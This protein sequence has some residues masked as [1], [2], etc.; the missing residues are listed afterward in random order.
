[1]LKMPPYQFPLYVS[2]L[3]ERSP[4]PE[5]NASHR[6]QPID[7]DLLGPLEPSPSSSQPM[8]REIRCPKSPNALPF[9]SIVAV[10]AGE[11]VSPTV[12]IHVRHRSD[13]NSILFFRLLH[14]STWPPILPLVVDPISSGPNCRARR[15]PGTQIC[16]VVPRLDDL[17]IGGMPLRK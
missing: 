6:R 15:Y 4:P 16:S 3:W 5:Q 14:A 10:G 13:A 2:P 17:P 9:T 1:M 12:T 8:V 7:L 11:P